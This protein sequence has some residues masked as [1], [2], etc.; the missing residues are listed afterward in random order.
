[1]AQ[2]ASFLTM[3]AG[4]PV[5]DKTGLTGKYDFSVELDLSEPCL[6]C[7]IASALEQEIGLRL[8]KSRPTIDTDFLGR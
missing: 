5:T 4:H 2:V 6:S 3:V 7:V 8:A 1:M